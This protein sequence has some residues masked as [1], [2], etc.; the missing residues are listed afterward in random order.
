[1]ALR[2]GPHQSRLV[3]RGLLRIHAGALHQ[4]SPYRFGIATPRARHEHRFAVEHCGVGVG[5]GTQEP[6]HHRGAAVD[7]RQVKRRR[8][9]IVGHAGAG[10]SAEQDVCDGEIVHTCS[11]M[12]RGGAVALRRVDIDALTQ[13][14]AHRL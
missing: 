14:G 6:I 13:Q 1:M 3:V 8:A 4:Q 9:V 12:Q 2:G 11:P 7:A 5:A 10:S